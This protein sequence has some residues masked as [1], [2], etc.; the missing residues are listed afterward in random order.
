MKFGHTVLS[1]KVGEAPLLLNDTPYILSTDDEFVRALN[2]INKDR[3]ILKE[4]IK[5][6]RKKVHDRTWSTFVNRSIKL[7]ERLL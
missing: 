6:N 7:W 4:N 2:K 5:I 1:T 3:N